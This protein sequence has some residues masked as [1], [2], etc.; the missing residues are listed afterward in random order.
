MQH[1]GEKR[2][3]PKKNIMYGSTDHEEIVFFTY[4][5]EKKRPLRVEMIG[6]THK[7]KDYYIE[8]KHN[9]Y[10]VFEYVKSGK[11]YIQCGGKDYQV[12]SDCVYILQPGSGHKYGSDKKE[13]Y[14]KVWINFFSS[15]FSDILVAY[16]HSGKVVFPNSGCERYFDELLE[17]AE[18][19]SDNEQVYIKVSEIIFKII[20]TLAEKAERKQETSYVAN[21]VKEALD[22]SIYRK[23][24]VEEIAKEINFSKSQMTREFKKYYGVTPYKYLLDRKIVI[25]KQLL[26]STGMRV[27]EISEALGFVDAYYFS[28]IFKTKTGLSPMAYRKSKTEEDLL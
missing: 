10:F 1:Y 3:D 21:L 19:N 14:E 28:D 4:D 8:R 20:L 24:T 13:P 27:Q 17:V 26:L 12:E 16:G 7:D 23:I 5:A 22:N 18:Q 9:D 25:A 6:I 15:I 11:G 2:I